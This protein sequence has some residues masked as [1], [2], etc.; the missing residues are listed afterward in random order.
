MAGGGPLL[1]LLPPHIPQPPLV[2]PL[3]Q[4]DDAGQP[5]VLPGPPVVP[6]VPQAQPGTIPLLIGHTSSQCVCT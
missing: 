1:P 3:Q 4:L 5:V 2:V 6:P